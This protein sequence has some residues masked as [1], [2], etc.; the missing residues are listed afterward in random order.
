V[1]GHT[2]TLRVLSEYKHPHYGTVSEIFILTVYKRQSKKVT[3]LVMGS[4]SVSSIFM[5][6]SINTAV[7][8]SHLEIKEEIVKV[9]FVYL[10]Q[11]DPSKSTMKKLERFQLART[12]GRDKIGRYV[13]LRGDAKES[14]MPKDRILLQRRG[15]CII[16]GSWKRGELLN[17]QHWNIE[18][19]LPILMASNPVNFG[20]L[21]YLSSVEALSAALFICGFS[22]QSHEAMSKFNWGHTFFELNNELLDLYSKLK[23][24][25][26]LEKIY[27]EFGFTES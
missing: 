14:L 5:P 1:G 10:H 7:I 8:F 6:I 9:A 18:R 20:K 22:T 12:I 23:S 19:K 4:M 21:N 11:D 13:I 25:E 2:R 16:E 24:Y 17:D 15:I 26:E 27:N 3:E